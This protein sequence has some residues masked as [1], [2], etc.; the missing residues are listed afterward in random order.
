MNLLY[1]QSLTTL[2]TDNQKQCFD[3][4]CSALKYSFSYVLETELESAL[5]D[6]QYDIIF[7]EDSILGNHGVDFAI[8]LK[9]E[10]PIRHF[11]LVKT[12]RHERK[13]RQKLASAN[14]EITTKPLLAPKLLRLLR[15]LS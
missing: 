15:A 5:H 13:K 12:M 11:F 2:N 7:L 6:D 3:L 4:V 9:N 10:K 1:I 8:D 14:I